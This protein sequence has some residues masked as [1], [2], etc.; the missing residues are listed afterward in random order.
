MSRPVELIG[1]GSGI[2]RTI[3]HILDSL[4]CY[5]GWLFPLWDAKKNTLADKIM[6]TYGHQREGV[7]L[8]PHQRG[9]RDRGLRLDQSA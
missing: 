5:I 2:L 3:C 8:R 9:S 6:K 7:T 1:A 4:I